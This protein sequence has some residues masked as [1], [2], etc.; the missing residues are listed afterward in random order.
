MFLLCIVNIGTIKRGEKRKKKEKHM[1][2]LF[3]MYEEQRSRAT[4]YT[5]EALNCSE[6]VNVKLWVS[7][8]TSVCVCDLCV[9]FMCVWLCV[10]VCGP[11]G[12]AEQW[13]IAFLISSWNKSNFQASQCTYI[14][15][16]PMC[17]EISQHKHSDKTKQTKTNKIKETN[18]QQTHTH[19]HTQ[20]TNNHTHTHTSPSVSNQANIALTRRAKE[21]STIRT[22]S[23]FSPSSSS[24]VTYWIR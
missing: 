4:W 9:W 22:N 6:C 15:P 2:T 17:E 23:L 1:P 14:F 7:E 24:N 18:Q 3:T 20:H 21:S 16:Q 12:A 10:C 13:S 5:S 19:T 11:G 8:I